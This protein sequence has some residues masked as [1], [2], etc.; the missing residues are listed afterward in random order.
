MS[1]SEYKN[2]IQT[3]VIPIS[4]SLK[5]S[6]RKLYEVWQETIISMS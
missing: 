3:I 2:Q 4:M 5:D 6:K 1:G